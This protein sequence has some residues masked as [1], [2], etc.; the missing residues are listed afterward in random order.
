[1]EAVV[2]VMV[3]VVVSMVVLHALVSTW[4]KPVWGLSLRCLFRHRVLVSLVAT[5][6][7][8]ALDRVVFIGQNRL[9]LAEKRPL[10][11][12]LL[13][14]NRALVASLGGLERRNHEASIRL[15]QKVDGKRGRADGCG[16]DRGDPEGHGKKLGTRLCDGFGGVVLEGEAGDPEAESILGVLVGIDLSDVE[17]FD[18]EVVE[19]R[20]VQLCAVDVQSVFA[21]P[22]FKVKKLS[23]DC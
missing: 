11:A 6:A 14:F 10:L 1:M 2:G 3:M 18:A 8:G 17:G 21:R 19:G 7:H 15:L 9:P 5:L 20:G 12:L 13:L 4:S 22:D 16:L 23:R